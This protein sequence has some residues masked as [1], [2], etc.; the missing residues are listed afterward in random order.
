MTEKYFSVGFLDSQ[1][2]CLKL[3]TSKSNPNSDKAIIMIRP[4][5]KKNTSWAWSVT[6][7]YFALLWHVSLKPPFPV[8]VNVVFGSSGV[9]LKREI[10]KLWRREKTRDKKDV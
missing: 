8:T 9:I 2:K 6:E 7:K 1:I 4:I 10:I 5:T 3:H